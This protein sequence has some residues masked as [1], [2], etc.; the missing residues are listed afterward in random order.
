MIK[1]LG[2]AALGEAHFRYVTALTDPQVRGLLK[3]GVI[4]LGLFD[5][6]P[7]EVEV[8]AKRYILRCDPQT[9][10]REQARRA[11]QWQRVRTKITARNQA[12]EQKPRMRADSALGQAQRWVKQ[13]RLG[14]W[15]T[16]R[17]EGRQVVWT[18][19]A[20]AREAAGQLD[21]CYVVETDVP[22]VVATTNQV[23]ARYVDLTKVERDFRTLKTGWLEIRPVFVRKAQ[24]TRGHALVSLLALKL[25]RELDRRVAPL[26]LTA[27]EA[28]E[29]LSG[30]RLI[31][32][33]DAQLGWWRLADSY[34]EAQQ[35]VLKVL[36]RLPAPLLSLGKPNRHRLKNP[37]Q[38]RQ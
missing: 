6:T 7:A 23:H 30:V 32:L 38:G 13:Y 25:A 22:A 4:Q 21:G 9:R 1:A 18:E 17:L 36:P 14:G 11:D 16:V 2:K 28:V 35:E 5:E 34:P 29:R 19:E 12:M 24:R 37:R 33:G 31:R 26:G 27:E 3:A 8:G 10:A 20:A 15:I